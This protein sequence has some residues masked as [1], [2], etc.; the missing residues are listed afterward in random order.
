MVKGALEVVPGVYEKAFNAR[1][2][3]L[4]LD[5]A[6]I[7]LGATASDR[8]IDFMRELHTEKQETTTT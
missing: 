5:Q 8:W 1:V 6:L 3:V 7:E 4:G 2:E